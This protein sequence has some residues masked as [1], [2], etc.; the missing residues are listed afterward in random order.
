MWDVFLRLFEPTLEIRS[1]IHR[2]ELR[3][4]PPRTQS[5]Q[6]TTSE[7]QA[8]ESRRDE[9]ID[10]QQKSPRFHL[11]QLVLFDLSTVSTKSPVKSIAKCH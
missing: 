8:M 3:E 7:Q 11:H 10:E 6:T 2:M 9:T 1:S 4:Q 5:F